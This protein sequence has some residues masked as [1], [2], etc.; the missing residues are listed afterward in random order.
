MSARF[1][2]LVQVDFSDWS[3]AFSTERNLDDLF[4]ALIRVDVLEGG[5]LLL[6]LVIVIDGMV[7]R[8]T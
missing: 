7:L 6:K 3:L 8:L 4:Q 2:V 5:Y 1:L